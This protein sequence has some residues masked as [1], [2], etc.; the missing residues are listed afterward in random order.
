MQ[1][2]LYDDVDVISI[3]FSPIFL[4][5]LYTYILTHKTL[6]VRPYLI[7]ISLYPYQKAKQVQSVQ[8]L[9]EKSKHFYQF[10]IVSQKQYEIGIFYNG[11][12]C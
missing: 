7:M 2:I 1:R 9:K 4:I 3:N 10:R 6:I 8:P 11:Q 5:L 12:S